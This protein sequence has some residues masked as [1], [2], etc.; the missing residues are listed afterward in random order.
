M[1]LLR[2]FRRLDNAVLG[3]PPATPEERLA[4]LQ[5]VAR[6]G[7]AAPGVGATAAAVLDLAKRLEE[8]EQRLARLEVESKG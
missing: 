8:A 2:G 3:P 4:V 6:G 5:R 1:G 7:G